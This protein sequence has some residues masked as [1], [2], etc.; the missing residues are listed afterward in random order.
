MAGGPP[1]GELCHLPSHRRDSVK[2]PWAGGVRS[3]AH[4]SAGFWPPGS[5]AGRSGILTPAPSQLSR[6]TGHD[7]QPT[8][9]EPAGS[10]SDKILSLLLS[11]LTGSRGMTLRFAQLSLS[12]S[13]SSHLYL[14]TPMSEVPP[15]SLPPVGLQIRL[16]GLFLICIPQSGGISWALSWAVSLC[17]SGY[18]WMFKNVPLGCLWWRSLRLGLPLSFLFVFNCLCVSFFCPV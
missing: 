10:S 12:A 3:T 1:A 4:P 17:I 15:G 13:L 6:L 16:S 7:R 5:H 9:R 14:S 8:L 18:L 11:L 2:W